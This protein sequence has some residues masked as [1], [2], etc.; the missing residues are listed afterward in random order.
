[1]KGKTPEVRPCRLCSTTEHTTDDCKILNDEIEQHANAVS[2]GNSQG[3]RYD[4]HSNTY[5]PGW[6][7]HPNLRYGNQQNNQQVD[8]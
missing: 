6:R 5:N 8:I 1:M 3:R 4:P 2:F 7:D